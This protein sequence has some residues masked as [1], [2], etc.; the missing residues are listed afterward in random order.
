MTCFIGIP[1][2][3]SL[4]SGNP[5]PIPNSDD[6]AAMAPWF[7]DPYCGD[8]NAVTIKK[9]PRH[10]ADPGMVPELDSSD[11]VGA[12]AAL[13]EEDS[14]TVAPEREGE[15]YAIQ[16]GAFSA[17]RNAERLWR[18]FSTEG[19]HVDIYENLPDGKN[20]LYLV[21]VGSFR[22]REEAKQEIR[23]IKKKFNIEG[24]LATRAAWK[25]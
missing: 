22:S 14:G 17:K 9:S 13:E 12:S 24:T 2:L 19:Y 5:S 6:G 25:S 16:I 10:V 21:W 7:G 8:T 1:I 3:I 23:E 11:D 18:K 15:E 20:L 4:L